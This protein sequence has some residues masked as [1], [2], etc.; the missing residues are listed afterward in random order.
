M[1]SLSAKE[2]KSRGQ[3]V[4]EYVLPVALVAALAI[5]ALI[6][7]GTH[8]GDFTHKTYVTIKGNPANASGGSNGAGGLS[9]NMYN[10][11]T[12]DYLG[13]D[14]ANYN[15]TN[16]DVTFRLPDIMGGGTQTTSVSG[17]TKQL[18]Q[19]ILKM[20]QD[21]SLS[22]ADQSALSSLSDLAN[23]IAT[24]EQII[25]N[26]LAQGLD[27]DIDYWPLI[28][29]YHNFDTS[30]DNYQKVS[31]NSTASSLISSYAGVISVNASANYIADVQN[32]AYGSGFN[33]SAN[34]MIVG[35]PPAHSVVSKLKAPPVTYTASKNIDK[36]LN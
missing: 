6:Q 32:N 28:N 29:A 20:S 10:L 34:S 2:F 19:I 5:P 36:A 14:Q 8:L 30:Y 25:N 4:S 17:V 3:A 11:T 13:P 16:G 18:A 27:G 12:N 7:V 35:T 1:Q 15:Y 33:Q 9:G 22:P 23:Q 21:K 24:Q 26:K 31:S